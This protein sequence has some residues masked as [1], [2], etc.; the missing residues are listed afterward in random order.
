[1]CYSQ[2]STQ[3]FAYWEDI[4]TNNVELAAAVMDR[5]IA[6]FTRVFFV[7][8]ELAHEVFQ[9]ETTLLKDTCL[10]VLG[11]NDVFGN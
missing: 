6:S 8:E 2:M 5:H 4:T 3:P 10:P 1:M 7:R 11:K 9:S